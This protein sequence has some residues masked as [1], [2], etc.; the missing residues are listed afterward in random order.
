MIL[1]WSVIKA[2]KRCER[3]YRFTDEFFVIE[4]LSEDLIIGAT[5]MQKWRIHL[6]FDLDQVIYE[7]KARKLR[8]V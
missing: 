4:R 7:K 5:T 1:S 3:Q 2:G 6:D 8:I